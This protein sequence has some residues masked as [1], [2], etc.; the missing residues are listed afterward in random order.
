MLNAEEEFKR[1]NIEIDEYL[2][3]LETLES[4]SGLSVTLMNTM[5]SSALLMIYN[6]VEST[7]TN[8]L[9]DLFD[10]LQNEGVSFDDLNDKMKELVLGF[11]KKHNP[12]KLVGKMRDQMLDIAVACFERSEVFSGNLD[13]KEIRETMKRIGIK[14]THA[15]TESALQ[16]VK[17]ERNNLAHGNKSFSD[18]G[19]DYTAVQLR[20]IQKKTQ[21]VLAKA[22][23]D[24]DGFLTQQAYA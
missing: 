7:M 5:K 1:R 3:H 16:D 10:H 15:Y 20:E 22:I 2:T 12:G 8:L 18:C 4:T 17:N 9:Q 6:I 19:K 21:A 24:F 23:A 14:M 13:S 11:V